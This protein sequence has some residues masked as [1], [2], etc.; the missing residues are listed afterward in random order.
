VA[1]YHPKLTISV[2]IATNLAQDQP[3][4]WCVGEQKRATS[5]YNALT[6]D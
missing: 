6:A 4:R 5:P 2:T 1:L 3:P